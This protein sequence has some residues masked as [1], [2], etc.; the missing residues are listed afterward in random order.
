MS[1]S[2]TKHVFSLYFVYLAFVMCMSRNVLLHYYKIVHVLVVEA[3]RYNL[4]SKTLVQGNRCTIKL[5]CFQMYFRTAPFQCLLFTLGYERFC[6]SLIPPHWTDRQVAHV[7]P[8]FFQGWSIVNVAYGNYHSIGIS[9][10]HKHVMLII[11]LW[12]VRF[13]TEI[14]PKFFQLVGKEAFV[15]KET[16]GKYS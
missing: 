13:E 11:S 10:C 12:K 8:L 2:R 15:T 4:V 9:T 1:I 14:G 6:E 16:I 3:L 7:R 5:P